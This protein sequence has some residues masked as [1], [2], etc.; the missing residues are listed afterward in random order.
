MIHW[1]LQMPLLAQKRLTKLY[2]LHFFP[3]LP[4]NSSK[5]QFSILLL[6]F[7][8]FPVKQS[9][10]PIDIL[11]LY[12][13]SLTFLN[14]SQKIQTLPRH[15]CPL[16]QEDLLGLTCFHKYSEGISEWSAKKAERDGKHVMKAFW[17]LCKGSGGLNSV[18][19]QLW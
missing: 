16:R 6:N 3:L 13:S 19:S 17:T 7:K 4:V 11:K 14:E 9:Q 10:K 12:L 1:E 18:K 2:K 15:K 5:F 8:T